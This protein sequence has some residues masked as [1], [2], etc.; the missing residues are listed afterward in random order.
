[1]GRKGVGRESIV[2]EVWRKYVGRCG[3]GGGCGVEGVGTV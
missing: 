2:E 3:D 1:M